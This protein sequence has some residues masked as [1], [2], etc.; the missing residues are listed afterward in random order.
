MGEELF[1]RGQIQE[2]D[3]IDVQTDAFGVVPQLPV[4]FLKA[5]EEGVVGPGNAEVMQAE[6][7]FTLAGAAAHEAGCFG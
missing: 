7:G 5:D 4:A 6:R 1:V 2:L 3:M